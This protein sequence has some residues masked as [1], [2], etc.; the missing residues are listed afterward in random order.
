MK[1]FLL[2]FLM[3]DFFTMAYGQTFTLNDCM[4]YAIEKNHS[5]KRQEFTNDNYR[6]DQTEAIAYLLPSVSAGANINA[7]YGR[8][9]DPETNTYTT[10]GNMGNS[11]SASGQLP[12]FAGFQNINALRVSRVMRLMGVE[13][14]QQIKDEIAIKTMQAYFDVVYFTNSVKISKEQLETSLT[15]LEQS[16]KLYELG[17]KSLAD[18]AQVES[19]VA[20]DELFLIQQENQLQLKILTL[21]QQMN[22]PLKEE[23]EI[24]TNVDGGLTLILGTLTTPLLTD[25]AAVADNQIL[26]KPIGE[27]VD[28]A[29][30]NNPKM[31][32]SRYN[33]RQSKLNL[34]ITQGRYAPSISANGGYSTNYYKILSGETNEENMATKP[35]IDQLSDNGG[36]YFGASINIPIFNGLSR[37]TNVHRSK[38]AYRIAQ[39]EESETEMIL[40]TEVTQA[41]LEMKGYEK[42]Y[43]QATKKVN[44]A[45]LSHNASLS[46]YKQGLIS[47]IDLQTTANQL[48]LAKSQQL[49][50]HLQFIVKSRL[51]LYY[52]GESLVK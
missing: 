10:T 1:R 2:I 39:E 11:Y 3:C 32:A 34:Y 5:V 41:V 49:N 33:V 18:V 17:R 48:L 24:D 6:Q 21:K 43:E 46:K 52:N 42:E 47:P 35:F 12:L 20:S 22:Y 9:I 16:Q 29:L 27:L 13:K 26:D 37:R 31:Q 38:N 44:A 28:Y 7:S 15:T 8:S 19:Q 4:Q 14:L 50:S 25:N 30:E 45:Q 23:L 40:K 51:V 36:Y